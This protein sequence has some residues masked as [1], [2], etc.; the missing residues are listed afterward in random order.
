MLAIAVPSSYDCVIVV[1]FSYGRRGIDRNGR[2]CGTD[3]L[4]AQGFT[5]D[6]KK[7]ASLWKAEV[8]RPSNPI[9]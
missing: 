5:N 4:P 3:G 7:S 9:P 6:F 1:I 2:I 8:V